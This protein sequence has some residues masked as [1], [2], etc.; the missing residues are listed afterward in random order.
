MFTATASHKDVTGQTR[1]ENAYVLNQ[2]HQLLTHEE[3][4]MTAASQPVLKM[5]HAYR[6]N[7][8]DAQFWFD[9]VLRLEGIQSLSEQITVHNL[10]GGSPI[11]TSEQSY[12]FVIDQL[13]N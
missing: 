6:V 3:A 5:A 2:L 4:A 12:I 1:I 8:H 7:S 11:I 10:Q 13:C 9:Q